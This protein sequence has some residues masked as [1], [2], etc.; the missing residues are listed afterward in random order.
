M[1]GFTTLPTLPN[2]PQFITGTKYLKPSLG[3]LNNWGFTNNPQFIPWTSYS[4]P[5]LGSSNNWGFVS[6][7]KVLTK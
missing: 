3:S 2:N 7:G 4:I 5:S 6:G 1:E